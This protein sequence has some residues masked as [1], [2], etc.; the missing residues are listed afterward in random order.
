MKT[1]FR[2]LS[3]CVCNSRKN[4]RIYKNIDQYQ[5]LRCK[6]CKL[7]YLDTVCINPESFLKDAANNLS[8]VRVEYWGYPDF[9]KKYLH[10]FNFYFKERYRRILASSPPAGDWLDIGTG[11]GLWQNYIQEKNIANLGIEIEE[12]AF[13]YSRSQG[14]DVK[15][16]SI[17]NFSS[18]RKFAVITICDV[19][20]HVENPQKVL[21]K[22]CD[23]LVPG[24]LIYIQV[25]NVVGFRIPYGDHLGLPHH[26][27]QFSPKTLRL[28]CEKS[29]L[30]IID[31]WTGIQGVIKYYERGGPSY[32]HKIIW[33]IAGLFRL[34]NRLQMIVKT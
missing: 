28:L 14:L 9:F 34:G 5:L 1:S 21:K 22:C 4:S 33:R 10:V 18:T 20:E 16:T 27:W 11:Y 7:V 3:C 32:F 31:Y 12:K 6:K 13:E 24:G 15:F 19:L 2:T 29:G 17:E 26:L 25:P 8:S 30:K 23:L